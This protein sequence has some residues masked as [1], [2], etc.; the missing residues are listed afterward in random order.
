MATGWE[1]YAWRWKTPPMRTD[2]RDFSQPRWRG[3]EIAGRTLFLHA[4]QGFGDTIQFCRYAP[5]AAARG[6]RVVLEVHP[7][8]HRIMQGLKGVE[9]TIARGQAVPRF[10]LH[11]PLMSLPLAFRTTLE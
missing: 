5:L 4:E 11:C 3:E 1:E 2:R 8:L 7:E 10:D 6:A 9:Q